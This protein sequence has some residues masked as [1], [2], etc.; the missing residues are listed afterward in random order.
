MDKIRLNQSEMPSPPPRKIREQMKKV[1]DK[2][3][4][5][6]PKDQ[7]NIL[8]T[9]L[10]NY[11]HIAEERIFL[12]SA[13]DIILKEFIFLIGHN[14]KII[15]VDPTFFL[16]KNAIR[17]IHSEAIHIRLREPDFN[18]KIEPIMSELDE[19]TLLLFDNPNNPTGNLIIGEDKLKTLLKHPEIICLVDEA[20]FE[21]SDTTFSHL[22]GKYPNLAILRTVSKS[23][24]L[25]GGGIGYLLM[26]DKIRE[27]F[28]GL[29]IKLPYPGVM[30][31]IYGLRNPSYMEKYIEN[32][33]KEKEKMKEKLSSLALKVF[34][35]YT[36][37][38]LLR[39]QQSDIAQKL[40]Q[41]NILVSDVSSQLGDGYIR[42]SMGNQKENEQFLR[43]L[44]DIVGQREN[45]GFDI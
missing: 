33:K 24:G 12:S 5:Y 1:I 28:E 29:Q 3:N 43:A 20:Y 41:R 7:V 23:L 10:A 45:A 40:A 36:N 22:L 38:F 26:G 14:R 9:E 32:V 30:G 35:S 34:P 37:F 8:K 2:I 15:S 18:L 31:C 11:T 19:P 25:A 21:F 13:S 4:R 39:S 6:T 16:I 44:E 27:M 42:V 17:K